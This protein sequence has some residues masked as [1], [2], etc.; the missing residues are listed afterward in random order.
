[1]DNAFHTVERTSRP[2]ASDLHVSPAG[3]AE[4]Q[5]GGIISNLEPYVSSH[6]V[7]S[8]PCQP[9]TSQAE[10]LSRVSARRRRWSS[11]DIHQQNTHIIGAATLERR[12]DKG[13]RGG[14][15][16]ASAPSGRWRCSICL[17]L[18]SLHRVEDDGTR[19][20]GRQK[21]PKAIACDQQQRC[22]LLVARD[23]E[24]VYFGRR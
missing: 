23:L 12:L 19:G 15:Q 5:R 22:L 13:S 7:R 16:A 18:C 6:S 2:R 4:G 10:A 3:R 21:I 11:A 17:F 24:C 9:H 1:M 14:L 8:G 20:V